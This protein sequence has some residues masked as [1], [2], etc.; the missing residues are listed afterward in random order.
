MNDIIPFY[1]YGQ[2][3]TFLSSNYMYIV[4]DIFWIL[5]VEFQGIF[6]VSYIYIKDANKEESS[7]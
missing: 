2:N 1:L 6:P 5:S 4:L 7:R 3:I